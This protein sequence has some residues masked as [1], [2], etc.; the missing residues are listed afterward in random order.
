MD[1]ARRGGGKLWWR[2][3]DAEESW[4]VQS[5][6]RSATALTKAERVERSLIKED[7]LQRALCSFNLS[8]YTYCY[9][10][11]IRLDVL[12]LTFVCD[13]FFFTISK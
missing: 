3:G 10:I 2:C 5:S 4:A 11:T 9:F 8:E 6:K 13:V 12:I 1:V 7:V